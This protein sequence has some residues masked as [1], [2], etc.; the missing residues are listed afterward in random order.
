MSDGG[1]ASLRARAR[2]PSP[3]WRATARH[4]RAAIRD[5]LRRPTGRRRRRR[6]RGRRRARCAILPSTR[7]RAAR[8]RRCA[9]RRA[10]V[11]ARA[12]SRPPRGGAERLGRRRRRPRRRA[13][14]RATFGRRALR[15]RRPHPTA[16]RAAGSSTL[17]EEE[18]AASGVGAA[19]AADGD[20]RIEGR[21]TSAY[22]AAD[23]RRRVRRRRRLRRDDARRVAPRVRGCVRGDASIRLS[24][25]MD[26]RDC[27]PRA[28]DRWRRGSAG[29]TAP[30]APGVCSRAATAP[31]RRTARGATTFRGALRSIATRQQMQLPT[32]RGVTRYIHPRLT[33]L[34]P[35]ETKMSA[36]APAGGGAG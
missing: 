24:N 7:A 21:R 6:R 5:A 16:P 1:A 11:R 32:R 35:P 17:T 33:A 29:S 13:A 10:L 20:A 3:T 2:R 27:E 31:D 19:A 12:A 28:I 26:R 15:A 8:G 30:R 9:A 25:L 4:R 34:A 14:R 36:T 18:A 23:P 22:E